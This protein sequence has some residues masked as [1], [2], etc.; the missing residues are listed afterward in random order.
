MIKG[1][2]PREIKAIQR[3]RPIKKT[4]MLALKQFFLDSFSPVQ[5]QT[6]VM[7]MFRIGMP[8]TIQANIQNQIDT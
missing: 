5:A 3:A 1:I 2:A 8:I 7:T 6:Q 4:Q